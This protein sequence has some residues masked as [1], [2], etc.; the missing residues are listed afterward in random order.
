MQVLRAHGH[1]L[2]PALEAAASKQRSADRE[3]AL[4][5]AALDGGARVHVAAAPPAT[6]KQPHLAR[7]RSQELLKALKTPAAQEALASA[8]SLAAQGRVLAAHAAALQAASAAGASLAELAAVPS[9]DLQSVLPAG[10]SLD[11]AAL[12]RDE[13]FVGEALDALE[14]HAGWMVS[15]N[16]A[17][18]VFYRHQRGTTVH[19]CACKLQR[20]WAWRY[21]I[22]AGRMHGVGAGSA[23]QRPVQLREGRLSLLPGPA[24]FH[25]RAQPCLPL[26]TR[27][28]RLVCAIISVPLNRR[29]L[30]HP[31][32][33][34]QPQVLRGAGPP[35][36][37]PAGA[38][39]RV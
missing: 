9:E 20:R 22:L 7:S 29:C 14:D 16:D 15:R 3:A 27:V 12:T 39:A 30:C 28:Q 24:N 36:G 37:A 31:G 33:W 21:G 1:L 35:V 6:A 26:A 11:V 23:A 10:A 38:G 17:L 4:Q 18:K 19:R 5:A 2:P 32:P 8:A 34:L 25:P 13:R